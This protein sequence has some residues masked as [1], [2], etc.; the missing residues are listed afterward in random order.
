MFSGVTDC[1]QPVEA[2]YKLTRACLEVCLEYRNPVAIISKS[3]LVER[4]ID[5]FGELAR[6]AGF[7]LSVSLAFVDD[8]LARAMEPWAPSPSPSR[9]FKVIERMAA[10]GIPVGVMCAPVIPGLNDD[11]MVRV[12][13]SAR[14]AGT[15]SASWGLLRLPGVVKKVFTERVRAA[16][17]LA[18]DKI[19]HRVRDTRGGQ[20]SDARFFRRGRGEGAYAAALAALFDTTVRRLGFADRSSDCSAVGTRFKRPPRSG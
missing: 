8:S 4:D 12:L 10:A 5:L 1:Y 20:L 6:Q 9:R 18:A 16:L 13:E 2:P 17:P 15:S 3:A 7:H 19:L 11:Q 14:A